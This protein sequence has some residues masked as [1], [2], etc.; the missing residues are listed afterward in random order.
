MYII[1]ALKRLLTS[2]SSDLKIICN[3]NQVIQSHKILF[4]L[5]HSSLEDI[6]IQDE[7]TS[8]TVT[9]FLPIDSGDLR[10][11][12][13][14]DSLDDINLINSL[15]KSIGNNKPD[16]DNSKPE[17]RAFAESEENEDIEDF[18][19]VEIEN[20]S[21]IGSF[22]DIAEVQREIIDVTENE[23]ENDDDNQGE[24]YK[25]VQEESEDSVQEPKV[26]RVKL[27]EILK[28]CA[29]EKEK[30]NHADTSLKSQ[31]ESRKKEN[32]EKFN[33]TCHMC[34]KEFKSHEN[35]MKHIDQHHNP[36]NKFLHCDK[37][38]HKTTCRGSMK[39][40]IMRVHSIAKLVPCNICGKKVKQSS[41]R[42]HVKWI[43]E[44]HKKEQ[45]E[46]CGLELMNILSL[47]QHMKKVHG[48]REHLCEQCNYM[49]VS[50][51]NLRL[52]INKMHLGIKELPRSQCEFCD[53]TT[54]N[55]PRHVKIYHA[56]KIENNLSSPLKMKKY[57]KRTH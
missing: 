41:L 31:R 45:C 48:K 15:F 11:A 18:E 37:C 22:M 53:V 14:F 25:K 13:D 5:L 23:S 19:D 8:Q 9:V 36:E 38:E 34:G 57:N 30:L 54:T 12:L 44:E 40:H 39:L 26:I 52:H 56:E 21:I 29:A 47:R 4:G 2:Y 32:L 16:L 24:E 42:E 3:N 1:K 49:A 6:F 35:M 27:A 7:Y 43:H 46:L 20:A 10:A 50:D 55:L 33:C 51:Y 17:T 28:N